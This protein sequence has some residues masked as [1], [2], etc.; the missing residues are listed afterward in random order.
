MLD[1][2]NMRSVLHSGSTTSKKRYEIHLLHM[3]LRVLCADS[4]IETSKSWTQ[5]L[6]PSALLLEGRG[7]GELLVQV[8]NV[9]HAPPRRVW[10]CLD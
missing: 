5:A 8:V 7:R 3:F 9:L 4:P 2:T 1:R 6:Q 10:A